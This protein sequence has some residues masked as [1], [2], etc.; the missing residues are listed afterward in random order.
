MERVEYDMDTSGGVMEQIQAI[1]APPHSAEERRR[2]IRER[3]QKEQSFARKYGN[4]NGG[5]TVNRDCCDSCREGGDLLCCD[6]CPASFHFQCCNPPLEED[7]IPTGEWICNECK[8]ALKA[9][10]FQKQDGANKD[11]SKPLEL[12]ATP[13]LLTKPEMVFP[14]LAKLLKDKNPR[15]FELPAELQDFTIFP[16]DRRNRIAKL[17]ENGKNNKREDGEEI[18]ERICFACSRYSDVA[19]MAACDFCP[20]VFHID[21][22]NPPM[23][24]PPTALW[25]CPNHPHHFEGSLQDQR[26]SIRMD[27]TDNFMKNVNQSTIVMNF[28]N[29]AKKE[30]ILSNRRKKIQRRMIV[31]NA[32][33]EEYKN[34]TILRLPYRIRQMM[35]PLPPYAK[36]LTLPTSSEQEEWLRSLVAL[37]C[38]IAHHLT[39]ASIPNKTSTTNVVIKSEPKPSPVEVKPKE[40]KE[41]TPEISLEANEKMMLDDDMSENTESKNE[42]TKLNAFTDQLVDIQA[43]DPMQEKVTTTIR[44]DVST[45]L[46]SEESTPIHSRTTLLSKETTESPKATGTTSSNSGTKPFAASSGQKII[47]LATQSSSTSSR[48]AS[49][50]GDQSASTGS[51]TENSSGSSQTKSVVIKSSS[52]NQTTTTTSNSFVS[53][54]TTD[55]LQDP[56]L[57]QL[58]TRLV[59]ALAFQRLQQLLG[60]AKPPQSANKK[61]TASDIQDILSSSSLPNGRAIAALCPLNNSP[62]V[63][64]VRKSIN[65]GQGA[66]NNVT[67]TNYGHC[68]FVS[69]KHACIF[70]DEEAQQFELLNYSEHGTIVDNVLYS[71]DFSDKPNKHITSSGARL[72]QNP[73]TGDCNSKR[74]PVYRTTKGHGTERIA[75]PCGCKASGSS[76]IGGSGAGWEGTA[77]LHH[78]SFIKF[79]CVH[80]VF[81]ITA[82]ATKKFALGVQSK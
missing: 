51:S 53:S 65:I 55:S 24:S 10:K 45:P 38:G 32:I 7:D 56:L 31:P 80:F 5:R 57:A 48:L 43:V 67:L 30:R 69:S 58:D 15:E 2:Y 81:S 44:S 14:Y 21:C 70:F 52:Q 1:I 50:A 46:K 78:G 54:I 12:S 74:P 59:K 28:L 34:P 35:E 62:T 3:E 23:V 42:S 9:E 13:P 68:N 36:P 22:L 29:R 75:N 6:R 8:A 27:G 11:E 63:S 49:V 79:G 25:M 33:K 17:T 18:L 4:R 19:N 76:L 72:D 71:C 16:G 64:M 39:K 73:K 60:Q 40:K 37:Q 26:Y 20:L 41:E 61:I 82:A 47:I 66:D 77:V